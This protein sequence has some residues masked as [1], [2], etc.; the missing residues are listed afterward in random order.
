MKRKD[1]ANL[2]NLI[3]VR[4]T[5]EVI[6]EHV[7]N[8]HDFDFLLEMRTNFNG[9]GKQHGEADRNENNSN[10]DDHEKHGYENTNDEKKTRFFRIRPDEQMIRFLDDR[11]SQ[12]GNEHHQRGRR[13][14]V[15]H[16]IHG[17][18]HD[19]DET[20]R[21]KLQSSLSFIHYIVLRVNHFLR[22]LDR[23]RQQVSLSKNE[24]A[25][26]QPHDSEHRVEVDVFQR[27]EA[28]HAE[29]ASSNRE[30]KRRELPRNG[31]FGVVGEIEH[32]FGDL[33][34]ANPQARDSVGR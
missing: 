24:R 3:I 13:E 10:R 16:L 1:E 17:R 21:Q 5:V 30:R 31:E 19:I 15:F 33:P 28:D 2:V 8:R 22:R 29:I 9:N 32:D 12:I 7:E 34:E 18:V 26:E 23:S 20:A 11:E 25:D 4:E 6:H 14:R 27:R